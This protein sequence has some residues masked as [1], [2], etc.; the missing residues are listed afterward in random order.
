M[1]IT[2]H[3]L[4]FK[5]LKAIRKQDYK[6]GL[7]MDLIRQ[8]LVVYNAHTNLD[9]AA[10]GVNDVLAE[11]LN[12]KNPEPLKVTYEEALYKFVVFVP[13]SHAQILREVL[14][15]EG[16]GFIGNYSHCTYNVEGKGTFMPLEGTSPYIG[17]QR[18][19]W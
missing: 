4:I 3:P 7:I 5:P 13:H 16:A 12:I 10:G 17:E 11:V 18:L 1:I 6:E 2:H 19:K 8:D 9:L 15:N 14:G